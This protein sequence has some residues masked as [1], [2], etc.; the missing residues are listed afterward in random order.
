V[1]NDELGVSMAKLSQIILLG[2]LFL[3]IPS[4]IDA[5]LQ[6]EEVALPKLSQSMESSILRLPGGGFF[7]FGTA[8][9]VWT[10][11]PDYYEVDVPYV[12]LIDSLH[13]VSE[14]RLLPDTGY[15]TAGGLSQFN[16]PFFWSAEPR[17]P[18]IVFGYWKERIIS[19]VGPV[20]RYRY[21]P[22]A[23]V[24][25]ISAVTGDID[26]LFTVPR[27]TDLTIKADNSDGLHFLWA[28][29]SLS[30][31]LRSDDYFY[32]NSSVYY[33]FWD[34]NGILC[35][36]QFIDSGYFPSMQIDANDVV[37]ILY[38]TDYFADLY[39]PNRMCNMKYTKGRN[40]QFQPPRTLLSSISIKMDIWGRKEPILFA[41]NDS[42]SQVH[43]G[44]TQWNN[45]YIYSM[46]V[47]DSTIKLDSL[48]GGGWSNDVAYE[49]RKTDGA[50]LAGWSGPEYD[51]LHMH[52]SSN[53]HG[54]IFSPRK[55]FTYVFGFN[56]R[57]FFLD[58]SIG[59][60]PGYIYS[61]KGL[62]LFFL[63]NLE[64]ETQSLSL[65]IPD[66]EAI[67]SNVITDP[68][69]NI[70]TVYSDTL[71]TLKLMRLYYAPTGVNDNG[72]L[73]AHDFLL[74]Q[75]YPNPFNP[76][77]EIEYTL[78]TQSQVRLKIFNIF[79]QEVTTLVNGLQEPGSKSITWNAGSA[80]SGVASG[81]Y[82]YR[83]EAVSTA[84]PG[85]SFRDVKKMVVV[86]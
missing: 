3:G 28:A 82:F 33:R 37:H 58:P 61:R 20:S 5:Q 60:L 32:A 63:R 26:T 85:K 74:R 80:A 56:R 50:L 42:G 76:S 78:P 17:G 47:T 77:T 7:I 53:L 75:N 8:D 25:T 12:I 40:G 4:V 14:P 67:S 59:N 62:G 15:F 57:Q 2:I 22:E 45:S 18:S 21:A 39:S 46:I 51:D 52:Y 49:Y 31:P 38:F 30:D 16:G 72:G 70:F 71:N 41:V 11:H 6:Y 79:G 35:D 29:W 10:S 13:A 36:P 66:M 1:S 43:I 73:Q 65:E 83:L 19:W 27:G 64:T 54:I 86:K 68:E 48:P 9:S 24:Y 55:T 34:H 23:K 84:E 81:V 44:W 69:G